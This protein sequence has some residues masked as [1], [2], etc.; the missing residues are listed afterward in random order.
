MLLLDEPTA[1]LGP[2]ERWS[3]IEQ[4]KAIWQ[5][6]GLTIVFIEHDMDIVF[7]TAQT[8]H[9]LVSGA[10]LASGTPDEVRNDPRVI[11][12]YLGASEEEDAA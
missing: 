6:L 12:A 11:D 3:M 5:E 4:V 2:Q 8:I 10:L 9:V 7:S 1:G